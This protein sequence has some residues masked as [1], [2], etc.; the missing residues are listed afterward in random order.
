MKHLCDEITSVDV[1]FLLIFIF[2]EKGRK[3]G[4]CQLQDA[5]PFPVH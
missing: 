2:G 3:R 1:V 5:Q 4:S